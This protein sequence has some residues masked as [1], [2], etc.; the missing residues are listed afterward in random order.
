M[1]GQRGRRR[2]TGESQLT[3]TNAAAPARRQ[4][5]AGG[6]SV[7]IGPPKVA[8]GP[9]DQKLIRIAPRMLRPVS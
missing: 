1:A 6:R 8:A 5:P 7:P 9:I 3:A 2:V 4:A